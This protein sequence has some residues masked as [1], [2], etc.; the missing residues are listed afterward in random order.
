MCR[1]KLLAKI[2]RLGHFVHKM[3]KYYANNHVDSCNLWILIA[4]WTV[5]VRNMGNMVLNEER[6]DA[7]DH[8]KKY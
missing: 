2:D 6:M 1:R 8:Q 3:W 4:T 5:K 7:K